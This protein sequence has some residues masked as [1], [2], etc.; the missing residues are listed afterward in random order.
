[1]HPFRK[2]AFTMAFVG[3]VVGAAACG[4]DDATSPCET[5]TVTVTPATATIEVDAT[6]QLTASATDASG[7]ACGTVTWSSGAESVATVSSSGLVT[8]VAAGEATIT[9]T[10]NGVTGTSTITV[11]QD[12]AP[13]ITMTAPA[14][15]AAAL[16]GGVVTIEWTASD[17]NAV[18]GVDLSYTADGGASE[19]IATDVQGSSYD[20]TTPMATL[21]GVVIQGVA[22]DASGQSGSDTTDDMFAIVQFSARGYVQGATCGHCHPSDATDVFDMSGHPYKLNAVDGGAPTY[23]NGPGVPNPPDG[24]TWADVTYVIGG[25]GWKARFIGVDGFIITPVTGQN[26]WNLL[27][28]TWT[29]YHPGEVRP[30]NCGACHTTGW[31]SLDD[32]GGVHQDGLVGIEGTWEETGI[33]CEQCHGAGADHVS[34]QSASDITVDASDDLCGTCHQRGGADSHIEAS[35]GW[36]RHHEQYNEFANS[37]HFTVGVGC[38]TCHDPHLGTRYDMGGFIESCVVCHADQATTNAHGVPIAGGNDTD[39]ACIT[40]HMSQ[41]TKSAVADASNPNFVGDVR[42]HI[43]TI[44]PGEFNKEYFF[45]ADSTLVETADEGVTLDFVCYQCHMDPV[46]GTGGGM[47]V[48]TLAELSTKATGIHTP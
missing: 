20:W 31:Q 44:N 34:T 46:T 5:T 6:E 43:F 2:L 3:L 41:A 48:K 26:Q 8:G 30:Y 37:M 19:V 35:G 32:N 16:P 4:D 38:N 45:N 36:I 39:E 27:P 33:S 1:M 23:P 22:K 10:A 25:Y 15:G 9:A 13:S 17:D 47:S 24:Y 42:T 11:T 7:A 12:L 40:C 21:Y 28:S 14:G 29:D 18:T